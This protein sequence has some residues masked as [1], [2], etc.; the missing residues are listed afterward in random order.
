MKFQGHFKENKQS[1]T[2]G[3]RG[4]QQGKIGLC[5]QKEHSKACICMNQQ[6][7]V[8]NWKLHSTLEHFS[9]SGDVCYRFEGLIKSSSMTGTDG[10]YGL[11][12]LIVFLASP[13][14][15]RQIPALS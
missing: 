10:F 7:Q 12:L 11:S 8:R 5:I 13:K 2:P 1:T 15:L 9:C 3:R 4:G 14:D 6:N